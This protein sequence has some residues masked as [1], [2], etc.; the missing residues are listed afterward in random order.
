MW[1]PGL[2]EQARWGWGVPPAACPGYWLNF[3]GLW[4]GIRPKLGPGNSINS[5]PNP[6]NKQTNQLRSCELQLPVK[7]NSATADWL[8]SESGEARLL[9]VW[10]ALAIEYA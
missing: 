2:D 5:Q 3:L 1:A 9:G 4:T 6:Q 10:G 8:P 7:E